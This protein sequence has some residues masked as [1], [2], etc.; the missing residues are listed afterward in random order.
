MKN[1]LFG[2]NR[3]N[4][5]AVKQNQNQVELVQPATIDKFYFPDGNGEMDTYKAETAFNVCNM[6]M[7]NGINQD[8]KNNYVPDNPFHVLNRRDSLARTFESRA[9]FMFRTAIKVLN[10]ELINDPEFKTLCEKTAYYGSNAIYED[11]LI[12]SFPEVLDI[13]SFFN[14]GRLKRVSDRLYFVNAILA[15]AYSKF[16]N[17]FNFFRVDQME[18]FMDAFYHFHMLTNEMLTVLNN[19]VD[20]L[21]GPAG[22]PDV[23]IEFG[24]VE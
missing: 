9:D 15:Y 2:V 17:E 22:Y 16:Y 13:T 3:N 19:E 6:F 14:N 8:L 1:N 20:E 12:R 24:T 10:Y 5:P 7:A 23:K 4:V 18:P 11:E 21:Y